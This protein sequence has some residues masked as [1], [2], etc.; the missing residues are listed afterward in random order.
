MTSTFES[1]AKSRNTLEGRSSD[2][3]P[4][5]YAGSVLTVLTWLAPA[6]YMGS[7]T[8]LIRRTTIPTTPAAPI[9]YPMKLSS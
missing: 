9:T 8:W 5:L 3:L 6:D 1:L 4:V 7:S 2:P